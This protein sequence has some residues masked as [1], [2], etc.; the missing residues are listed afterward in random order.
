M[1]LLE[2]TVTEHHASLPVQEAE[3]PQHLHVAADTTYS[4]GSAVATCC[5]PTNC[6]H[7]EGTL[8]ARKRVCL[9]SVSLPGLRQVAVG[10]HSLLGKPCLQTCRCMSGVP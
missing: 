6:Q 2:S 4:K 1:Q 7:G 8:L 10:R 5:P 3:L 9:T